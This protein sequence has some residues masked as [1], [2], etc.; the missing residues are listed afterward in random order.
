MN[1]KLQLFLLVALAGYFCTLFVL[2][3]KK[4][5]HLKYTLL[6]ILWGFVMLLV[7]LFPDVLF[8]ISEF[9]GITTPSNAA[10]AMMLFCMLVLL[11]MLTAIVSQRK[12]EIKRLTQSI[13][14]LEKRVRELEAK[15][16]HSEV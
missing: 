2:L 16:E 10:F 7:V 15:A 6:W 5:L 1:L 8:A 14:I 9:V 4:E 13:A 12:R 3:K 11:M